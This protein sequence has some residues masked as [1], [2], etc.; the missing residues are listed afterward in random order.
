MHAGCRESRPSR[1]RIRD[2]LPYA[3]INRIR[4]NGSTRIDLRVSGKCRPEEYFAL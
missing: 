4:F 1:H 2:F 3:G